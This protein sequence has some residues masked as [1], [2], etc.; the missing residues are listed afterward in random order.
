MYLIISL[1]VAVFLIS[2]SI[3]QCIQPFQCWMQFFWEIRKKLKSSDC[4]T[5][6]YN[7]FAKIVNPPVH[8]IASSSGATLWQIRK[9]VSASDRFSVG[10]SFLAKHRKFVN[11]FNRFSVGCS[12]LATSSNH[13]TAPRSARQATSNQ[14]FNQHLDQ[15]FSSTN[16]VSAKIRLHFIF[17]N[18]GFFP[19]FLF[20][21]VLIY[22]RLGEEKL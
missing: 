10:C 3:R 18:H 19:S 5:V 4:F 7:K 22:K 6:W 1:S 2:L 9:S 14:H 12:P 11:A 21:H 20:P 15:R 8:L 17:I 13:Q 16:I